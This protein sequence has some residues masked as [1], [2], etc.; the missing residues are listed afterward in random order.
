L[1]LLHLGLHLRLD[2][3]AELDELQLPVEDDDDVAQALLHVGLF[4]QLLLLLGLQPQG[5]GDEVG[6]RARVIDVRGGEA[7]LL[8]Q[9]GEQ[10][11]DAREERLHCLR[12]R[13]HLARLRDDVRD[14]GE[15]AD[16]VRLVAD[17][18]LEPDAAQA[19]D[20]DALRAVGHADHLLDD[21]GS[22]D[23]VQVVPT[24]LLDVGRLGGDERDQ[25]VAGHRVVDQPH[26]AFLADRQ[27]QQRVGEDDGVLQGQDW[28]RRG[29][30]DLFGRELVV[31]GDLAHFP[32]FTEIVTRAGAEGFFAAGSTIVSTPRR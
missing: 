31:E 4:E 25:P 3:R 29:E 12:E 2:L 20:E 32:A 5:R 23:L 24:R 14:L 19:L 15:F 16:Q 10:A 6:E 17:L 9:V 22:A 26:R 7:E 28:K 27:G 13:L 18:L 1:G 21:R 8:G 11:D 30:L